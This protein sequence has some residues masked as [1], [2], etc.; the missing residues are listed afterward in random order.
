MNS[1]WQA[2]YAKKKSELRYPDENLV[3][4]LSSYLENKDAAEISAID[5]GCGSGRHLNLLKDFQIRKIIGIDNSP[6]AL[7]IAASTRCP[8]IV[9]DNTALPLKDKSADIIIAW[10]SLHYNNKNELPVMINEI[11]RALKTGGCLFATLRST[12]DTLMK[13]GTHL[14]NDVWE[15]SLNDI[16]GATVS[17]FSENELDACFSLF[18]KMQYGLIERTLIGDTASLVSHWVIRAEK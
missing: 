2:H 5:L 3:R 14:G 12:R 16:A 8:L 18:P 15:T 10:G 4:L 9:G 7:S 13:K 6:G 17:F 11:F 1:Q